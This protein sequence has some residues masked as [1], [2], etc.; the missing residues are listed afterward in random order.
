MFKKRTVKGK[1]DQSKKRRLEE[2][3]NDEITTSI[4]QKTFKKVESASKHK[5]VSSTAEVLASNLQ[6]NNE[7]A[8]EVTPRTKGTI[9]APPK[10]INVT[11]IT[12][13][14]PDVCKD[15][16]QTGYCGYGDTCK[17]LHI[18]DESRQKKP[19][20]KEWENVTRKEI[21]DKP[22][23]EIPFKCVL[24]KNEYKSPIKTQCGHLF[25]K[26]CFLDEYKQK[27]TK[28]FICKTE[29]D[30]VMV[31]VSKSELENLI[32]NK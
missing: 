31:P 21:K 8:T 5:P 30:G 3:L 13:F 11:T 1:D 27:K 17:F 4:R 9:K 20:E 12:D 32:G 14:Q 24:C 10:N 29:T 18:R 16:L 22:V 2:D 6:S 19:I 23:E 28:C 15:F 25:C 26:P 7:P